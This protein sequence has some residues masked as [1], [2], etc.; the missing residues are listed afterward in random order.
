M[1]AQTAD[2]IDAA[3]ERISPGA[4]EWKLDGIRVQVH[5][6]DEDV[7]VFTRTLDEI[8]AR[9]P[10]EW[11]RHCPSPCGRSFFLD[12][13]AI[14]LAED[15]RP[16]SF[17]VTASR[18]GTTD[19]A[20]QRRA[21]P[22]TVLFFDVLYVDERRRAPVPVRRRAGGGPVQS[23][24][25]RPLRVPRIVTASVA[26]AQA[27]LDEALTCGHEGVVVK[28]LDASPKRADGEPG[29]SRSSRAT[30]SIWSCSR[31]SGDT[32]GVA[33]GCRTCIWAHAI[34]SRVVSWSL[35]NTFKGMT[36][37]MLR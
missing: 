8:G 32:A 24:V 33:V 19:V 27:F 34:R 10:Q 12:G 28:S 21:T 4:V 31:L 35:G 11:R 16:R 23:V 5:R 14:A 29:G 7:R 6:N 9:L 18:V 15:D 3:F 17:Q 22:L 13:E 1:L 26:D 25:P 37:A 20:A 36:D 2:S 30:R